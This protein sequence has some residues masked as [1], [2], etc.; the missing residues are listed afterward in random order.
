MTSGFFSG[1]LAL[2]MLCVM[3]FVNCILFE[4]IKYLLEFDIGRGK[5]RGIR[6]S[7]ANCGLAVVCYRSCDNHKVN[8]T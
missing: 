8:I 6:K 1:N 7:R 5:V 2:E 4:P 3:L